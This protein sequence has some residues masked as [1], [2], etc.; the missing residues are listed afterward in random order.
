[1]ALTGTTWCIQ[2]DEHC[3]YV[4]VNH[5]GAGVLEVFVRGA[6]M[7]AGV[8]LLASQMLRGGGREVAECAGRIRCRLTGVC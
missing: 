8:G 1:M 5:A 4:T 7:S 2:F 6:V 3:L